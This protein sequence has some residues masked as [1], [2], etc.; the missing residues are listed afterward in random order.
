MTH[1]ILT[2]IYHV[3]KANKAKGQA[4]QVIWY[5]RVIP[6]YTKLPLKSVGTKVDSIDDGA[7]ESNNHG[8]TVGIF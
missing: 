8:Y 3:P 5:T 6:P 1:T 2:L 4:C 7:M